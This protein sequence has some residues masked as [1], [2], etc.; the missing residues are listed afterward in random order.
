MAGFGELV[1]REMAKRDMSQAEL[2]RRSGLKSGHLSP[3]LNGKKER[4]PQ[5]STAAKIADALD[6]SLDYL[7]G[8]TDNPMGFCDEEL[9]GLHIDSEARALLRGFELLPPNGREAIQ[10]QV[11]FQLSK[12]RE[13]DAAERMRADEAIGV[14]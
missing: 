11:D 3:Y 2:C 6:V 4:D 13:E 14:A 10:D 8:R 9:E 5:L 1:Q 7:A 12:K